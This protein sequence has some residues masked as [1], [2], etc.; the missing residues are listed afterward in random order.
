MTAR[1]GRWVHLEEALVD[2]PA[3]PGRAQRPSGNPG[4]LFVSP[5]FRIH[6]DED[7]TTEGGWR[8]ARPTVRAGTGTGTG[9]GH[10]L[11]RCPLPR[12]CGDDGRSLL[13]GADR[14]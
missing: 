11:V 2:S 6:D 5:I 3:A 9:P 13:L 1:H 10:R 7:L 14:R 12:R 4:G 8:D